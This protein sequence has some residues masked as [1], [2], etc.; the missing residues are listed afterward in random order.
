MGQLPA[1]DVRLRGWGKDAE[2]NDPDPLVLVFRMKPAEWESALNGLL[3]PKS[4]TY[5][6]Q[7]SIIIK[8]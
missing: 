5:I 2:L 1:S 3:S 6:N 8:G 4:R 7:L